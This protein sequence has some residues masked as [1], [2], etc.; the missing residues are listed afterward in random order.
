MN[1]ILSLQGLLLENGSSTDGVMG[2][3]SQSNDCGNGN[4]GISVACPGK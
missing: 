3:S 1:H 2:N 4:S